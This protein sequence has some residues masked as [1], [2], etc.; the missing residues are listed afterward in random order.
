[1][2]RALEQQTI[3]VFGA[4]GRIGRAV[5]LLLA[6]Q[7][8]NVV[9]HYH[10]NR[11]RAEEIA[12]LVETHHGRALAVQADVT[13]EEEVIRCYR[14]AFEAFHQISG[15][16]NLVHGEQEFVP[17]EIA[18]MEWGHWQQHMDAIKANFYICKQVLPYLRAAH[19]GRIV[20]VSGGLSCRF[21]KGCSPYSSSKAAMHAF[22]KTLALEEGGH[23]ISVNIV[24]PGKVVREGEQVGETSGNW[25]EMEKKQ[26]ENIP[27]GRFCT[28]EDVAA[29]V[30]SFLLPETV[31][32]TGQTV[33][34][35]GGEIMPMP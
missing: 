34:L 28:P 19:Y 25:E 11:K 15:I 7:G 10:S 13:R 3:V 21:F 1:M 16:V 14:T 23:G 33:Y 2:E 8:A 35:A 12:E 31:Y 26:L 9:C 4:T 22:C 6:E 17:V 20:Y 32:V 27:C 24:A 5:C 29:A 18:E 30:L